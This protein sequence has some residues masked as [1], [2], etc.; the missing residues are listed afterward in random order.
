MGRYYVY[1]FGTE[2]NCWIVIVEQGTDSDGAVATLDGLSTTRVELV[3][4]WFYLAL[5]RKIG[6]PPGPPPAPPPDLK[7]CAI[8]SSSSTGSREARLA[9]ACVAR[10][11]ALP[12]CLASNSRI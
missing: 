8:A 9:S 10:R 3:L 7:A 4:S 5:F 1:D 12:R 6:S 2:Q 11:T